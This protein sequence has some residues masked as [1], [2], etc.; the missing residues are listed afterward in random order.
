VLSEAEDDGGAAT[1]DAVGEMSTT[2]KPLT[3]AD[4]PKWL[5]RDCAYAVAKLLGEIVV[6]I[7]VDVGTA[8]TAVTPTAAVKRRPAATKE[9]L[10]STTSN[11]VIWLEESDRVF[12]RSSFMTAC[13]W[14]V[15]EEKVT[16]LRVKDNFMM[17][18][19]VGEGVGGEAVGVGPVGVGF[20]G[21]GPVGVGF[22][23]VGFVGVVTVAAMHVVVGEPIWKALAGTG[24]GKFPMILVTPVIP[25]PV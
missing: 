10:A 18:A 24:V 14:V 11:D 16:P 8:K 12:A 5:L 13:C 20:V 3:E 22:V 4:Q 1:G 21:V 2:A 17:E 7:Y 25:P 15:S 19:I 9:V 23:G 6:E